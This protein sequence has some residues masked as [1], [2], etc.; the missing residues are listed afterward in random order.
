M[1]SL[2]WWQRLLLACLVDPSLTEIGLGV[3]A[4][5]LALAL[6]ACAPLQCQTADVG[7]WPHP[8]KPA[9]AARIIVKCDGSPKVILDAERVGP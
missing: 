3:V 2:R 7:I 9:P 5:G 6:T 4:L 1:T 8:T